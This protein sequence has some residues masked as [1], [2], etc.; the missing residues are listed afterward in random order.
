MFEYGINATVLPWDKN[1]NKQELA[2]LSDNIDYF[3][4]NP[5][6][7]AL[8]IDRYG[9]KPEK[10]I[11]VAHAVRDLN[12]L[13]TFSSDNR[14]RLHGYG[15]VSSWLLNQSREL[16]IERIPTVVPIGINYDSFY[17]EPNKELQT[18]GYAGSVNPNAIHNHIKRYWLIEQLSEKTNLNLKPAATYH[19][20]YVT[21]RGFY[22]SV[23]AVIIASTEEGAG[24][25][26]LEASAAGKLVI[27]TPV[28]L[29][30]TESGDSGHTVP[31]EESEFLEETESLLNFYKDNPDSYREKCL[32]TQEHA[33]R[34]DWSNVIKY[35]VN[36]LK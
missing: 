24:L 6:G 22:K 13:K 25:P 18:I 29:W 28:G 4:A 17:S 32:E 21:M 26:A 3:V 33:K 1:Y 30:L 8:L 15:V 36:L 31:I 14:E 16:S 9:I 10:C 2:E 35:W 12:D 5:Y 34:Y 19:N 27:S 11:V 7:V 20:S 23:D